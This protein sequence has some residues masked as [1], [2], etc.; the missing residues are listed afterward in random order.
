MFDYSIDLNQELLDLMGATQT[1]K[2]NFAH[3]E[4]TSKLESIITPVIIGK[5]YS[6]YQS[7]LSG[8]PLNIRFVLIGEG[9]A[10]G[11]LMRILAGDAQQL[12][13]TT[14]QKFGITLAHAEF[15]VVTVGTPNQGLPL[16]EASNGSVSGMRNIKPTLDDS[17]G[18]IEQAL[19]T[20]QNK[21]LAIVA[22]VALGFGQLFAVTLGA[23]DLSAKL[24]SIRSIVDSAPDMAKMAAEDLDATYSAIA[25][26]LTQIRRLDEQGLN[27]KNLIGPGR[28]QAD[29]SIQ[30]EGSLIQHIN[31]L[32]NPAN[33]RSV[34]GSEKTP[35]PV[36]IAPEIYQPSTADEAQGKSYYEGLRYAFKAEAT[37]WDLQAKADLA[38]G[39]VSGADSRDRHRR[40]RYNRGRTALDNLDSD[41]GYVI[42]SYRYET[43]SVVSQ[44][45]IGGCTDDGSNNSPPGALDVEGFERSVAS[46][47]PNCDPWK[48]VTVTTTVRIPLKNDGVLSPYYAVWHQGDNPNDKVH[49]WYYGDSGDGGYNDLELMRYKRTYTQGANRKGQLERPMHETHDWLHD[50]VLK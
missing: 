12:G 20:E 32:P 25:D 40:D 26:T 1:D 50:H 16:A 21:Y 41:W 4:S 18:A 24:G 34:I 8:S 47:D 7:L 37:A 44:Q 48:T 19:E 27:L 43:Q 11:Y 30:G 39:L 33:Y 29:N 15:T 5:V 3:I 42:G 35:T 10:G 6:I 38:D 14:I 49:N 36:R 22:D 23:Y 13:L 45:Y 28:L 9:P 2:G 31:S 46:E 17:K